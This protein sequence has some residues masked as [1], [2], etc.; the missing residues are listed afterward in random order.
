MRRTELLQEIRKMRFEKAYEG[1]Q[2]ARLTQEEAA[3]LLGVVPPQS[4]MDFMPHELKGKN[5]PHGS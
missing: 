1:W 4:E 2:R 5:P 3:L